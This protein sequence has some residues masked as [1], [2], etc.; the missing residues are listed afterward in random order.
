MSIFRA[1]SP[2][3]LVRYN[4]KYNRLRHAYVHVR[5]VIIFSVVAT[6]NDGMNFVFV[7]SVVFNISCVRVYVHMN[8]CVCVCVCVFFFLFWGGGLSIQRDYFKQARYS[9]EIQY[10]F[11]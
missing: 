8:V 5:L 3:I 9:K 11:G 4:D 6:K 2:I 10:S 7:C 1:Q